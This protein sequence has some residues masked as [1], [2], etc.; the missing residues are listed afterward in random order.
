MLPDARPLDIPLAGQP[1]WVVAAPASSGSSIWTVALSDGLVQ[2]FQISATGE[3]SQLA[4]SPPQLPPGMPPLLRL[5]NDV[6]TLPLA[7]TDAASLQTHPVVLPTTGQMVSIQ[8]GGELLIWNKDRTEFTA[9]DVRT[10]PDA[11]ILVD[12]TGRLLLL[13]EPTTRY[14][15]GVLGDAVEAAGIALVETQPELQVISTI[16]IPDP[17]VIEGI[18]PIWSDLSGDG[19]REIIVTQSNSDQGAQIVV[20]GETGEQIATGPAIGR[21]NRWRHQLVVAPFGPAGEQELV[22]VLTP[23]IGGVV[24][25]YR[26]DGDTLR[27]VASVPGYTSHIIGTRNLDMAIGGDFDGDGRFELLLPSQDRTELGAIRRTIDGAEVVWSVPVG[28]RVV[29]NLVGT[30]LANGQLAVGVGREDGVLR[31]WLP[32]PEEM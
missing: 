23:H 18:A 1:S 15:H 19:R 29:S 14:Q 28:G 17:S 26:L 32:E 7:T 30:T 11:R 20:Y 21:G 5:A 24:E 16:A 31:V 8:A 25:F 3:V 22:D 9:L 13:T 12:E 10:L 27:I 2:S 4:A 6:P